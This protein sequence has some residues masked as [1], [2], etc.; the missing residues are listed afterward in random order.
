MSL[1]IINCFCCHNNKIKLKDSDISEYR[2]ETIHEDYEC[3]ICLEKFKYNEIISI[4]NKCGHFYH[5]P[6]L[7][8]WFLKKKTCPLCDDILIIS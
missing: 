8:T 4:I 5:T 1:N 3:L 2:I 7:Y 6:C